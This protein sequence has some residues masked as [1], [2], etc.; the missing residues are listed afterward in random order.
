MLEIIVKLG[1]RLGR[2]GDWCAFVPCDDCGK[3]R[4]VRLIKGQPRSSLCKSCAIKQT[5]I[6][7]VKGKKA[8]LS[9]AWKGGVRQTADGY[10]MIYMPEHPANQYGYVP[11]SRLVLEKALGRYL[12]DGCEPHHKDGDPTNDTL[13][14][15]E[16][17]TRSQHR[18]IEFPK[19]R[20]GRDTKGRFTAVCV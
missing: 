7:Y 19:E 15:L 4:W 18:R 8:E 5:V 9:P 1:Q 17:V 14:N 20:R 2:S 11:R 12:M 10:T 13:R 16:E 6:K 3:R